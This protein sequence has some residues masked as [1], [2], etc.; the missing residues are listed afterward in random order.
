MKSGWWKTPGGVSL[1]ITSLGMALAILFGYKPS[2]AMAFCGLDAENPTS[3]DGC[4]LRAM[5]GSASVSSEESIYLDC[6]SQEGVASPSSSSYTES[7]NGSPEHLSDMGRAH[8]TNLIIKAFGEGLN[9]L[10]LQ[11][12]FARAPD[13]EII[14]TFRLNDPF[15]TR[16][17]A[18]E[19]CR[20]LHSP[21]PPF[22]E[23]ERGS[24]YAKIYTL[25]EKHRRNNP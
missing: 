25:L 19:I 8:W 12:R 13:N 5:D 4:S 16:K 7:E 2:P 15:I 21:W 3:I 6:R 20:Y 9:Q 10:D 23:T 24:V 14:E 22:Q 11:G 18:E 1:I 17:E